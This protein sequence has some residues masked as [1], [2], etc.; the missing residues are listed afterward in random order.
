M[1]TVV[2]D[3]TYHAPVF[4]RDNRYSDN[5]GRRRLTMRAEA[6]ALTKER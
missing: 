5:P 2:L 4:F 6:P 3:R 1:S